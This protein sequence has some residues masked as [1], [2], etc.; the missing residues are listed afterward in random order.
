LERVFGILFTLN[1]GT[2]NYEEWV[3]ACLEGAWPKLVGDR[4]AAV[5]RPAAFKDSELVVD[6]LDKNWAEAVQSVKSPLVDKLQVATAGVV[7]AI[8]IRV[9][10]R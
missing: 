10:N 6:V 4:L 1:R 5:C 3:I 8:A 7:K 2:T 9:T